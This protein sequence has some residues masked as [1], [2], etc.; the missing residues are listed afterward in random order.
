[1]RISRM[2]ALWMVLGLVAGAVGQ[3]AAQDAAVAPPLDWNQLSWQIRSLPTINA[4]QFTAEQLEKV[5]PVLEQINKQLEEAG[6]TRP[7]DERTG[8]TL[9]QLRDGLLQGTLVKADVNDA[10]QSLRVLDQQTAKVFDALPA[11]QQLKT[12]LTDEQ[13]RLL[14]GAVSGPSGL[15]HRPPIPL[16]PPVHSGFDIAHWRAEKMVDKVRQSPE[17]QYKQNRARW[18]NDLVERAVKRDDPN[19]ANKV[20]A[21]AAIF[22]G[23]RGLTNEQFKAQR[24]D[25]IKQIVPYTGGGETVAQPPPPPPPPI[26][27]GHPNLRVLVD[28]RV[29]E[30]LKLKLAYLQGAAAG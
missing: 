9:S 4:L 26:E 8:T 14:E 22:D 13:K 6:K 16:P 17:P 28:P 18:A 2:V 3:V 20:A 7:V 11:V 15:L 10:K 29:I 21:M 19:F 25:L 30:L 1:M 27:G 5:I 24:E 23:I 12:L